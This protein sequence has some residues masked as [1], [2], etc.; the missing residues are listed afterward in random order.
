MKTLN[1]LDGSSTGDSDEDAAEQFLRDSYRHMR[2]MSSGQ[3]YRNTAPRKSRFRGKANP[4]VIEDDGDGWKPGPGLARSKTGPGPSRWDPQ[5]LGKILGAET[6]RRAW[7]T[8][9]SLGTIIMN[10]PEIVGAAVAEHSDVES[11]A[12]GKLLV[13][14]DST[15]W[16]RQLQLL[17]P[18]IERRLDEVL[19]VGSVQQV[20]VHGPERPSWK[21]G[22]RSVPGRGPRDTYG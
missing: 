13:R 14:A 16:A 18:Q 11:F 15:A 5:P 20:I 17:V 4:A 2:Q 22:P 19:G 3:P 6:R 7:G 8:Q 9:L 10:W 1:S 21:H 12:E